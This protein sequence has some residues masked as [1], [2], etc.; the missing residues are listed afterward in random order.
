MMALN[1][2]SVLEK[3]NAFLGNRISQEEI[4]EWAL[5]QVFKEEYE[6]VAKSDH[7]IKETIQA[8]ID[9]NHPEARTVPAREDFEFLRKCL[10]GTE[11]FQPIKSR[12][13]EKRKTKRKTSFRRYKD[14]LF[15][16]FRVYVALFAAC[17]L[18]VNILVIMKP[19]F[20]ALPA[21]NPTWY[22]A[23]ES[24]FSHLIYAV[25]LLLPFRILTRDKTFYPVLTV[26]VIGSIYYWTITFSMIFKMS[27]HIIMI[28]VVAPFSGIP[29]ILAILLLINERAKFTNEKK[30]QEH[31]ARVADSINSALRS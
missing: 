12:H 24:V 16:S 9:I 5:A 21:A 30:L 22:D 1:R 4:Y 26:F 19:D 11:T 15:F 14:D 6:S 17:S 25:L 2:N 31:M 23:F 27:F 10:E 8:L 20:M 28:F 18:V 29:T 7:L 13:Q 3:L